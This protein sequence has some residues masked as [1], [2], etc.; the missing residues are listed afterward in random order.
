MSLPTG[1]SHFM[2]GAQEPAVCEV[3]PLDLVETIREDLLVFEPDLTVRFVRRSFDDA[4][5]VTP[6]DTP[7]GKEGWQ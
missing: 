5:T 6:K 7:R 2:E 4:F 1:M 3:E